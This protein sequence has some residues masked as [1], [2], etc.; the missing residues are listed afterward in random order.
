VVAG[1]G[2][3]QLIEKHPRH[4]V[5]EMLPGMDQDLGNVG[6]GA[7]VVFANGAR[8]H[9]GLDELR[10]RADD[11]YDFH[12]AAAAWMAVAAILSRTS[13][14]RYACIGRKRAGARFLLAL[15]WRV[16]TSMC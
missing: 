6:A 13:R 16:G 10:A 9:R 12:P 8:H 7:G 11:R 2:N 14:S 15:P 5:V 1:R 4:V 3:L